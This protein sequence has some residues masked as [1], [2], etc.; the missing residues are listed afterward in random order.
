MTSAERLAAV[1]EACASDSEEDEEQSNGSKTRLFEFAENLAAQSVYATQSYWDE[2]H[3]QG[4]NTTLSTEWFVDYALLKDHL[5]RTIASSAQILILGCGLSQL[6][7]DMHK[8][9]F[10][11]ILACD[12]SPACIS[13]RV[14]R[15]VRTQTVRGSFLTPPLSFRPNTSPKNTVWSSQSWMYA[16]SR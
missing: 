5:R 16:C 4:E 9:N 2:R 14:K 1:R 10:D 7:D 6:A 8:D 13:Q 11:N 15:H 3:Q 12:Y